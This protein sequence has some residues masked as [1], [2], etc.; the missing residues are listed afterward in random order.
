MNTY[1]EL[2]FFLFRAVEKAQRALE[3]QDCALAEELL[4]HA[5]QTAEDAVLSEEFESEE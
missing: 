1:R 5:Q 2:Y 3:Q 4:I